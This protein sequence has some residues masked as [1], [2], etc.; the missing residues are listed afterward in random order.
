MIHLQCQPKMWNKKRPWI[1]IDVF[2]NTSRGL[3][4]AQ[5]IRNDFSTFNDGFRF[6]I[7][8]VEEI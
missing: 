4:D 7:V 5:E 6:R 2:P 1:S 8:R 3:K